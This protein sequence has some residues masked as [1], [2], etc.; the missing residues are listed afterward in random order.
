YGIQVS[1]K[2]NGN[3]TYYWIPVIVT[4]INPIELTVGDDVPDED[5]I[6][7]HLDFL[8]KEAE[9]FIMDAEFDEDVPGQY[10]IKVK[11]KI[12]DKEIYYTIPV[13]VKAK[14]KKEEQPEKP[15]P[16]PK[17]TTVYNLP[18]IKVEN[19]DYYAAFGKYKD[20]KNP[21]AYKKIHVV[22]NVTHINDLKNLT[23]TITKGG[24]KVEGTEVQ[25]IKFNDKNKD[26]EYT[27]DHELDIS[28]LKDGSVYELQIKAEGLN[29][30][31]KPIKDTIIRRIRKDFEAPTIEYTKEHKDPTAPTAKIKVKGHENMT[32]L[33]MYL[34]G[35]MLSRV[36]KT[37]DTFELNEGVT[38]E[39]E[40]E[41]PLE[42]GENTFEIKAY[43]DAGN[44]TIK[45]VT[46]N[47]E[48]PK[49][50]DPAN[51]KDL[52]NNLIKAYSVT[53]NSDAYEVTDEQLAEL[54][55]LVEEAR[56]AISEKQPQDKVDAVNKKLTDA[57][58]KIKEK[59]VKKVDKKQLIGKK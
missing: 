20:E 30:E 47:R 25:K 26:G 7:K 35:N 48:E 38:G 2:V 6:K 41:V 56:K 28:G 59:E 42:V 34:D 49:V 55:K 13:I 16:Q 31:N 15:Q 37:W 3:E 5:G 19:P 21:D 52:M 46:I 51:T 8:P 22:G 27:F 33:E 24:E 45:E 11:V 1:V 29:V 39:F 36:D 12:G 40:I 18:V 10:E 43:D 58:A 17:D 50:A 53:E 54:N 14:E 9:V 4:A 57:L 32:Y 44:E 23:L